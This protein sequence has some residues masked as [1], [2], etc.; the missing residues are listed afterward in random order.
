MEEGNAFLASFTAFWNER[1]A[2]PPRDETTAHRPWTGTAAALEDALA[3]R[4]DRTLTKALT[5]SSAGTKYCVRTNGPGT[6]LRGARVTLYH[7]VGGGMTVHYKDRVMPVTAYGTYP[8]PDPVE[9]EK[10]IDVRM[11]A[12]LGRGGASRGIRGMDHASR[13]APVGPQA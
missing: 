11:D 9:D 6:A 12:I 1:F 5:F 13:L 4:E 8:V 7:F 10:T 2:V 3:R